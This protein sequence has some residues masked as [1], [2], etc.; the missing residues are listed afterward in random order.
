MIEFDAI[1]S[2]MINLGSDKRR[3]SSHFTRLDNTETLAMT[4]DSEN[5]LRLKGRSGLDAPQVLSGPYWGELRIFLAV[6]QAKSYSRAASILGTSQPTVSR[7]VKRLQDMIGAQLVVPTA[8]GVALTQEGETLARSLLEVDQNLLAI[9]AGV[10]AERSGIVGT[11]RI[12]VTEGLSALFVVPNIKKLTA[13]YQNIRIILKN[14]VSMIA[15]KDNQCDILLAFGN[16]DNSEL[17]KVQ[18]GVLHFIP[19]ASQEYIRTN[20]IPTRDNIESH[21]FVDSDFYQGGQKIWT[22]WQE[23]VKR[24]KLIHTSE[25]SFAYALMVR[26]GLGIGLLGNY[27]LADPSAVPLDL[28]LEIAVPMYAYAYKDRLSSKPVKIVFDWFCDIFS[29]KNPLFAP[30]VNIRDIPSEDLAWVVSKAS[31]LQK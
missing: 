8:T 5:P 6:A 9:S 20:G 29:R 2:E 18:L 26:S 23:L 15:F 1:I 10:K 28:G 31:F 16:V 24:G 7:N 11:V 27:A 30:E 12:A 22:H 25:N 3:S 13:E 19:V 17:E 14:P 21:F 4:G